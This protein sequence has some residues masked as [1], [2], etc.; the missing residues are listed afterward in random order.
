[1]EKKDYKQPTIKLHQFQVRLLDTLS[2]DPDGIP[3][4][5]KLNI[6]EEDE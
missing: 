5:K 2:K 3:T 6:I 4:A 1:M